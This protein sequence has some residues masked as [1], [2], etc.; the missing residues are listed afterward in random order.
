MALKEENEFSARFWEVKVVSLMLGSFFL[1]YIAK[2]SIT[3]TI[4]LI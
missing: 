4:D 3:V 1:K 2:A